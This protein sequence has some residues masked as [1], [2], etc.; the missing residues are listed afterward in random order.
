[1]LLRNFTALAFLALMPLIAAAQAPPQTE[2]L[3]ASLR[4]ALPAYWTIRSFR[5]IERRQAE[6]SGTPRLTVYFEAEV[7]PGTDLY[8]PVGLCAG[9]FAILTRTRGPEEP[10]R[11]KGRIRMQPADGRW[12]SLVRLFNPV[13]GL[14][15]PLA[16][17][18]M[19]VLELG[20]Q[21]Q[22]ELV[23]ALRAARIDAGS[24]TAEPSCDLPEI[25]AVRSSDASAREARESREARH[26]LE[27]LQQAMAE[28]DAAMAAQ[29]AAEAERDAAMA[30]ATRASDERDRLLAALTQR[31][32]LLKQDMASAESE[33]ELTRGLRPND[34]SSHA[35]SPD[36]PSPKELRRKLDAVRAEGLALRAALEARTSEIRDLRGKLTD[37]EKLAAAEAL[38]AEEL[39][40]KLKEADAERIALTLNLEEARKRAEET[41]N[42][43]GAAE[44]A[45]A[46]AQEVLVQVKAASARDRRQ[47][48]VLNRQIAELHKQLTSLQA[49]LDASEARDFANQVQVQTLATR[50]NVALAQVAAEQ[51]RATQLEAGKTRS[52]RK[53]VDTLRKQ[54]DSCDPALA[55]F[56][57]ARQALFA[58]ARKT[59]TEAD[60]ITVTDDR[61]VLSAA[62]L[63]KSGSA[64]LTPQ[65]R[66]QIDRMAEVLRSVQS[67]IGAVQ[68]WI[69]RVDGHTDRTGSPEANWQLSQARALSVLRYLVEEKGFSPKHLS[70]NGFGQF[71]PIS[72]FTSPEA[73]AKNRRIEV[74]LARR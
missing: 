21:K 11:L 39:R 60:G 45:K 50:L 58:Q 41:L 54:A 57:T 53:E 67:E 51:K 36:A 69:L 17:F 16:S 72:P 42:L 25:A 44:A 71:Q 46:R 40:K 64:T 52:L 62:A 27:L 56:V 18:D 4:E 48:A 9:P 19:P 10:R 31:N 3:R 12:K 33:Q 29:R 7:V 47:I 55:Q 65:G 66:R 63:F 14:G 24:G 2:A 32:R 38:A 61:F 22:I 28:R 73:L 37:Q 26:L 34:K 43:L 6:V 15:R 23:A 13:S 68:G 70:A 74:K 1:M 20:S 5:E 35:P 59:L 49:V 8:L 30:R